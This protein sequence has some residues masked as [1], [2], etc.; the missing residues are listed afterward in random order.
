MTLQMFL[1]TAAFYRGVETAR[2]DSNALNL[3]GF[4]FPYA[5]TAKGIGYLEDPYGFVLFVLWFG[6]LL[7]L[8]HR[9]KTRDFSRHGAF[10]LVVAAVVALP[11]MTCGIRRVAGIYPFRSVPADV[12]EHY[13]ALG[14]I[15]RS[16]PCRLHVTRW[17]NV[18]AETP[19]RLLTAE[20]RA[21]DQTSKAGDV[22]ED[23]RTGRK[24]AV[25]GPSKHT[26]E[27]LSCTNPVKLY[28]GDYVVSFWLRVEEEPEAVVLAVQDLGKGR[29]LASHRVSASDLSPSQEFSRVTLRFSLSGLSKLSFRVYVDSKSKVEVLKYTLQPSCLE[30]L[31]QALGKSR[32]E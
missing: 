12:F 2:W 17:G 4:V 6:A 27:L 31:V 21:V 3:L 7:V 28:A 23:S 20:L 29:S 10:N 25:Y 14:D 11:V 9:A 22:S 8:I 30:E 32:S 18:S 13:S 15:N 19:T 24:P 26:P 1:H 16:S 5:A